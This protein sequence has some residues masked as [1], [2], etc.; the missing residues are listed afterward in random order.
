MS[1]QPSARIG[2]V[3]CLDLAQ[4]GNMD[5]VRHLR[6]P[7]LQQ[8]IVACNLTYTKDCSRSSTTPLDPKTG[9]PIGPAQSSAYICEIRDKHGKVVR[10]YTTD[11]LRPTP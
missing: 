5:K 8:Y 6:Q 2:T 4:P 3:H 9:Q 1:Q 11:A 10:T 7:E